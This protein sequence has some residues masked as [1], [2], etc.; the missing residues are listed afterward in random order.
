MS[1]VV[2][3][4]LV[5]CPERPPVSQAPPS[6]PPSRALRRPARS[7]AA[8]VGLGVVL[9]GLSSV[10]MPAQ[11]N[12]AGNGL[13]INEVY[14]GGGNNGGAFR[15]DFIELYNPSTSEIPLAG[16]SLQYRSNSGGIG[17]RLPLEGSVAP[18][19]YYLVQAAAGANTDQPALPTPDAVSTLAL[20]GTGGQVLLVNG[21]ADFTTTGDLAGNAGLVDMVGWGTGTN[22]FEGSAAPA[23]T[24]ATSVA[25]R[26][27]GVDSDVNS[28]DLVA[29][30]PTPTASGT[31]PEEPEEPEEPGEIPTVT[32]AEIQGTGTAT[33]LPATPVR[34]RGVVTASYPTGGFNGFYIQTEGTGGEPKVA[35][36][37][38]DAV[39]VYGG[40]SGFGDS[41]PFVGDLVEVVGVPGEFNGLTQLNA[42]TLPSEVIV[43][44]E[45]T[46]EVKA[47]E[48][49]LPATAA[50]R[51]MYEGELVAPTESYTVSNNFNLNNFAELGLAVGDTPLIT[52]TEVVAADDADGLAAVK[53]DNFARGVALDDGATW[54]YLTSYNG[55]ALPWITASESVRV[56]AAATITEPVIFDYRNNSWKYQPT[57]QLRA[58]G[59][60]PATFEDTRT[61]APEDVGGDVK[62][63]TF[64]VLNYFSTTGQAW[65]ADGNGTCSYYTDRAGTPIANDSCNPN[66]PRGAATAASLERQQS[67]IVAAINAIDADVVSL[68]EIE[69]SASLG[70]PR[71]E[72]LSTL[73][74][75][76]NAAAGEELWA[77]V[78]SPAV[79]PASEDVIRTAFIYKPDA[80]ELAGPSQILTDSANFSNARQPLAQ[81]FQPVGAEDDRAF[82][83]VVNHFKS[84]S[85]SG[86][87]SSGDN[88]NGEQGAWNGDRVRQATDL[89]AFTDEVAADFGTE[90][91]FLTGD[92]NSYSQEDPMQVFYEAGYTNLQSEGEWSYSFGGMSGSLDH[93]LANE[94]ALETVTGSDIWEINAVE[95]VAY[96]YSR[97]NYNL[98]DF[99]APN[100]YRSSDH[101]PHVVG[102]STQDEPAQASLITSPVYGAYGDAIT[103]PVTVDTTGTATG[104]VQAAW[105]GQVYAT[106]E[107][108]NGYAVLTIPR[109]ALLPNTYRFAITYSG[110]AGT[111]GAVAGSVVTIDPARSTLVP[112]QWPQPF[113][114]NRPGALGIRVGNSSGAP[115]SGFVNVVYGNKAYRAPLVNGYVKLNLQGMGAGWHRAYIYYEGSRT[116]ASAYGSVA[117]RV[118][119]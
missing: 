34:T 117:I 100:P 105:N 110:D 52:P 11:A 7:L 27:G 39:F 61:P 118:T 113:V 116:V 36:A 2:G 89:V 103:I 74:G 24:N 4:R 32:I 51:E 42:S 12:P 72:A 55:I 115:A 82:T 22:S 15:N 3:V 92:F 16:L 80:L 76:L 119:R 8:V 43:V 19:S 54:N 58:G 26:T 29:G 64:N 87:P 77:F 45:P 108:V 102:I 99:H 85:T 95:S 75:A 112:V 90:A 78:P 44:G 69:N 6:A 98:T 107:V 111:Q 28:A 62:L 53:A 93:V 13:V 109:R 46:V 20:S 84:K 49:A 1:S 66:G 86:A 5:A 63:A 106:A 71:D 83:V 31:T 67:K 14:G 81:A 41:T 101:E 18:G 68:E 9:T 50:E 17:G 40:T 30:A 70:K 37:A 33:P 60:A 35:P 94:A 97:Y 56:N 65:V 91:V 48:F 88:A 104:T 79:V 114:A 73:V 23:T 57:R 47:R 25:R 59:N 21:T 10:T 96:E 38:S